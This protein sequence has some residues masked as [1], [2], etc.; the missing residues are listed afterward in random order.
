MLA[1]D[2]LAGGIARLVI[3]TEGSVN[4]LSGAFNRRFAQ[5]AE[6]IAADGAIAGVVIASAKDDFAAGGNLDELRAAATPA[7][8]AALVDPFTRGLRRLE[9]CGKPVVAALNGSAL[10]GGFEI[11]LGCH[12]RIAAD[13][14]DARF[15]LP[16]AGLGL[17]PGAGG[18]QRLA[19]LIGVAAAADLIL[20]GTTLPPAEA[21]KA[22]LLDALVPP[23]GLMEACLAWLASGPE[24]V[25]P[26]DRKGFVLPGDDPQSAKGRQFFIGA[27]ARA[28]SRSGGTDAASS[29]ILHVLHHG[30]QRGLDAGLVIERRAFTQ[31]AVS[32]QARNRMRLGFYAPRAARP[33][34]PEGAGAGL[35]TLAVVGGGTMGCGIAFAAAQAGLAVRLIEVDAERAAASAARVAGIAER[36]VARGRMAPEAAADLSARV[37]AGAD[38]AALSDADFAIEAVFERAEVK[39]DVL[40]RLDTALPAH[41]VIASNTSTLPIAGLAAVLAD[42]SRMVGMH[43]FAPVETMKLVEI[44]HPPVASARA[45]G[46][47]MALAARLRKT[48]IVVRDG[49]GF[50][51]SRMV[52]ALSS[53]AL[54]CLAEGIAPQILDNVMVAQGFA[55]GPATLADLTRLPLLLDIMRSMSGPGAPACMQGSRAVEALEGLVA[56]GRE[57][58][59]AGAGIYDWEGGTPRRWPGLAELFPPVAS[60]PA[61]VRRRLLNTQ[62]LEA[63]RALQD[64]TVDDPLVADLA[65]HLGWGYPAHLGGP[66]AYVDGLGAAAFLAECEA[67]AEVCGPRF[68]P[69]DCLRE[70]AA[71]GARFHPL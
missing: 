71:R 15:G 39:H 47:A 26:W 17:M 58:K 55:V 23:E 69:P 7:E 65:A 50:Y 43:F 49:P 53:E 61:V 31:L 34:P 27:W 32:P 64:G 5:I 57:G 54:T 62:S 41:A 25:Q 45:K 59:A 37:S 4:T 6:E 60:D 70:M 8:V 63:I 38:Y 2:R 29:A 24:P 68:A 11:A 22:G 48:P 10:G 42:P 67:L 33:R 14:P 19:R 66:F 3:D 16:E 44:I 20:K 35:K 36:Q 18:T 13:R 51:T 12:R 1:L 21:L 9:A 28:R 46:E 56:A 30:V 52:T 40:R